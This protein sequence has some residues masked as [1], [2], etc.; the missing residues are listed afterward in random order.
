MVR[1]GSICTKPKKLLSQSRGG[2]YVGGKQE[3][4][5]E[6]AKQQEDSIKYSCHVRTQ[7]RTDAVEDVGLL[8]QIHDLRAAEKIPNTRRVIQSVGETISVH[9]TTLQAI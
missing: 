3:E 7:L 4:E 9:E 6:E 2:H 8:E 5:E 1:F